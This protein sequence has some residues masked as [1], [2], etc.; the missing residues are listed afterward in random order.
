[1]NEYDD[2][3][4]ED[5]RAELAESLQQ[6]SESGSKQYAIIT[7]IVAKVDESKGT[8]EG[9]DDFGRVIGGVSLGATLGE[10]QLF[11]VFPKLQSRLKI[12]YDRALHTRPFAIKY[13]QIDKIKGKLGAG[14]EWEFE[15][16]G[17]K[18]FLKNQGLEL[19]GQSDTWTLKGDIEHTGNIKTTGS[20]TAEGE[21]TA[22]D[23]PSKVGLS[24]HLHTGNLGALTSA[25]TPGT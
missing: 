11:Y 16:S 13:S 1:M 12:A 9:K 5:L 15:W 20:I 19:T 14:D 8:C 21:V 24:T 22:M 18:I 25:P 4:L 3:E 7:I 17:E 2:I 10:K 23:G 6:I